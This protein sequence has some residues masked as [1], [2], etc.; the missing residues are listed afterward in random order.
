[1]N[2]TV[3]ETHGTSYSLSWKCSKNV[4]PNDGGWVM[5]IK[6]MEDF[7]LFRRKD[8]NSILNI[9]K[10]HKGGE[11]FNESNQNGGG[12]ANQG[13]LIARVRLGGFLQQQ[14]TII[15]NHYG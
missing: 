4:K 2:G 7:S 1:M 6:R 5:E 14:S 11:K 15:K 12:L 9:N 13:R 10:V 3:M 8:M